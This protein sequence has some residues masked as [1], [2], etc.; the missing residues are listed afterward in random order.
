MKKNRSRHIRLDITMLIITFSVCTLMMFFLVPLYTVLSANAVITDNFA[1]ILEIIDICTYTLNFSIMVIGF[2]F[3]S[4]AFF[5]DLK[6]KLLYVLI[7]ISVILFRQLSA[8]AV[9]FIW[10]GVIS[11]D[12][13]F[14][15]IITVLLDCVV[16]AFV[17]IIVN[18]FAKNHLRRSALQQ[19]ASLLFNNDNAS[20]NIETLYPFK[21]IYS[22]KNPLQNCILSIGIL[23]SSV[24]LIQ[25]TYDLYDTLNGSTGNMSLEI[26]LS[27]AGGYVTDIILIII[28]YAISCFLLSLLYSKN[29]KRLAMAKLYDDK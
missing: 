1:F 12:D 4:V 24:N 21:K 11:A 28:A 26:G 27:I 6:K 17:L 15:S 22:T 29:E 18:I 9:D 19:K 16:L 23:L 10:E 14:N 20:K 13:I 25:R 2:S 7:Y 5:M 8:V 3:I